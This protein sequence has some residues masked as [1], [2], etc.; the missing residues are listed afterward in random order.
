MAFKSFF[1]ASN[2]ASNLAALKS[3]LI[4]HKSD[5]SELRLRMN[6]LAS[7][8]AFIVDH[9][10]EFDSLCQFNIDT[11]GERLMGLVRTP[12][13]GTVEPWV[14]TVIALIYRFVVEFDLCNRVEISELQVFQKY[15]RDNLDSFAGPDRVFIEYARQEMP[16]QILKSLL[17]DEGLGSVR[18]I[19]S[20]RSEVDAKLLAWEESLEKRRK[21]VVELSEALDSHKIGFNFVGLSEGF[22][23]LKRSKEKELSSLY[24]NM[25][26]LGFLTVI[27]LMV[28]LSFFLLAPGVMGKIESVQMAALGLISVSMTLLFVYFFR[29]AVRSADMCKAQ[30]LQ[31]ELRLTLC[32]FIQDYARYSKEIKESNPN[33]LEK[34][35]SLI[36][37]GIVSSDEKLPSTFDGMDQMANF[38]KSMRG[39]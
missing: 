11:I 3:N 5:N 24:F 23:S 39:K 28:E 32:Q 4:A 6:V 2:I 29:L 26:S 36:F 19:A 18:N 20:F 37:S 14:D 27:P 1:T 7:M 38:V 30:L 21:E 8:L 13:Q 22:A 33:S 31:I 25:R 15:V 34:F 16:I 35:E 10:N 9:A 17:N 12:V